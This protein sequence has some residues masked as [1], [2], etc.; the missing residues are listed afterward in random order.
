[1]KRLFVRF[2]RSLMLVLAL[3]PLSAMLFR[4]PLAS[5]WVGPVWFF[6]QT[7][8]ASLLT[9]I[10]AYIGDYREYE[11][12]T[13]EG[14]RTSDPNPDREVTRTLV[15]EGK[16]FPLRLAADLIFLGISIFALLLVPGAWFKG[17]TLLNRA[18]FMVIMT[19]LLLFAMRDLPAQLFLWNEIPGVFVGFSG[20]LIAALFLKFS[21]GDVRA[22]EMLIS[23]S[24][25]AYLFLGAMQ[26]NKQSIANSMSAHID[27][28]RKPPKRIILKNRA[29]VLGFSA[30]VTVVALIEPIRTGVLWLAESLGRLLSYIKRLFSGD[31]VVE[32]PD[33]PQ[34]L[35]GAPVEEAVEFAS[36][37]YEPTLLENL[38]VYGFLLLLAIGLV[39]MLYDRIRALLNRLTK[40]M[41]QFTQNIGEG[42][43]DEREDLMSAEEARDQL[44]KQLKNRMK[45]MFTR[46]PAWS[47]LS[48]RERARRLLKEFY[49][50]RA[51]GVKNLR[52]K[53]AREAI[54]Q[55]GLQPH[56]AEAF[57][58][59]YDR[60]RYSTRDVTVE[61]M[62]EIKKDLRL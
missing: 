26:L 14:G 15:K 10:P 58:E 38:L 46:E 43:Y 9:L 53:T 32:T 42:F 35:G 60:A 11:V 49:K 57:S 59:A 20:Y 37:A 25:V 33:M 50:K 62:D 45:A 18:F 31:S 40:W 47:K 48:G 52:A 12:M 28:D 13:Y 1:M 51:S 5:F 8:I 41:E 29:I 55:T 7:L 6:A 3:L 39:W 4:L 16:R 2:Q 21:K 44:K 34:F 24:S 54:Y 19:V 23:L 30:L 56:S 17:G 61:E 22:L 27:E 36:E